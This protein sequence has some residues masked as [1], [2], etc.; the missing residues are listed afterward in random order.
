MQTIIALVQ[1]VIIEEIVEQLRYQ[2]QRGERTD[3]TECTEREIL[4]VIL[5]AR[6]LD[7][8]REIN[9]FFATRDAHKQTY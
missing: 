2:N 4:M 3:H 7:Q 9:Q 5:V 1:D 6:V 8:W